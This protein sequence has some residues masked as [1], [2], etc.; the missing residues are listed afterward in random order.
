MRDS[1]LRD[2]SNFLKELL[3]GYEEQPKPFRLSKIR[4][5]YTTSFMPGY[6]VSFF[7]YRFWQSPGLCRGASAK[8]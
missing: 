5:V 1:G 8:Y 3:S 2:L 4:L 6:A 7:G